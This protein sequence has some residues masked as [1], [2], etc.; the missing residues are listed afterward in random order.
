PM[1][2]PEHRFIRSLFEPIKEF[3]DSSFYDIS[4][5]NLPMS[6]NI[7]FTALS[8]TKEAEALSGAILNVSPVVE[9]KI[10]GSAEPYAYLFEWNEYLAPK[11]L[12]TLL[13]AGV[14]AKVAKKEFAFANNELNHKFSYGTIMIPV[15]GQK[16]G[17]SE[18]KE[19]IRSVAA[20]CGLTVYG[21]STGYTETGMDLG[22]GS[23]AVLEKPSVAMIVGD[24]AAGGDA[25]EIWHML[26]TRFNIPVTMINS[27][28]FASANISKYNV[29]IIT[30]SPSISQSGVENIRRWTGEGGV[31]I[32]YKGGNS[33]LARNKLTDIQYVSS[34]ESNIVSGVYAD[35]S[36]NSAANSIPGSIFEV[37][38]DLTHPL[39]Y[40]YTRDRLP[41]F[42][43]GTQIA[44]PDAGI[45]NNPVK[46]AASPLLS[47]YCTEKNLKRLEGAPFASIHGRNIISIY[48]N[49][50]FRAIWYGSSKI[51]LNALFFGQVI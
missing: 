5:W 23:F 31:V 14:V 6:F 37:R 32:G 18:L 25:G 26:D 3:T 22:S 21:V 27:S 1:N 4:T 50:N 35:R 51:F 29:L 9:G 16:T 40:G 46:Y 36:A 20:E 17:S 34:A 19:L 10:T 41:V 48:D 39:C 30:G 12:Y 44:K 49:T 28:R 13:D 38:L 7:P 2:Q 33:W 15:S 45:Y 42:K 24:G 43:S 47:G 8:S 11:A